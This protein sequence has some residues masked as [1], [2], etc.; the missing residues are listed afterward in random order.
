MIAVLTNTVI[1]LPSLTHSS[2]IFLGDI[3]KAASAM[4]SWAVSQQSSLNVLRTH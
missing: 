3:I 2:T 1:A 4:L